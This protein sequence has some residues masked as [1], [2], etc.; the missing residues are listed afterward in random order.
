MEASNIPKL[1][2]EVAVL[3]MISGLR[4]GDLKNYLGRKSIM[5]LAGVLR[6][7]NEK[8]KRLSE[9]R[10]IDIYLGRVAKLIRKRKRLT[11]RNMIGEIQTKETIISLGKTR[12]D[13]TEAEA[14]NSK[15][16]KRGKF[17]EYTSLT[18]PRT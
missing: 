12:E 1:Q 2:Q 7:D 13:R 11:R 17:N 3:T 14:T 10:R 16:G 4:D 6:K 15:L 5:I 18:A 8:V 9:L